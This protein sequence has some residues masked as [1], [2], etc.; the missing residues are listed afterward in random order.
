MPLKRPFWRTAGDRKCASSRCHLQPEAQCF[1]D[2]HQDD[3]AAMKYLEHSRLPFVVR[4]VH[5]RSTESR[6]ALDW[7][8]D[9]GERSDRLECFR[10]LPLF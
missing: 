2:P 1:T 7:P 9:R 8:A 3:A 4:G 6:Q 10:D 5:P